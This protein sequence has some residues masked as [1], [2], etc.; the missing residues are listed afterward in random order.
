MSG[1][2]AKQAGTGLSLAAL[3]LVSVPARA[4]PPLGPL[5]SN[6]PQFVLYVCHSFGAAKNGVETTPNSFG[7][8]LERISPT[9]LEAGAQFAAPFRHRTLIDMQ[10]TSRSAARL[11]LGPRTT[12][13][14]NR[15]QLGPTDG[16]TGSPWRVQA[17]LASAGGA[18]QLP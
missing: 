7:L 4:A 11:L 12:W 13:D 9:A 6:G 17:L 8:R 16:P 3:L 15:R 10:F 14:L 5:P 2:L 18:I 1:S